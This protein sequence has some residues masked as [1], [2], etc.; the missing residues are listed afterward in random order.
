[1]REFF[2]GNK[3]FLLICLISLIVASQITFERINIE[4]K[5]NK[6]DIVLDYKEISDMAEQSSHSVEWWLKKFKDM[7]INKVGLSEE[8]IYSLT[9]ES[10]IQVSAKMIYELKKEPLW[11]AKLPVDFLA[12]MKKLGV[13][14]FDMLVQM[15]DDSTHKFVSDA[16]NDRY[17][18]DKFILYK[19]SVG[20]Y[21]FLKGSAEEALYSQKEKLVDSKKKGF[22]EKSEI[23][24][25]KVGYI[26][27]GLLD[28]KKKILDDLGFEIIPRTS[29]YDNW[30]SSKYAKAVLKE[31][32]ALRIQPEYMIV[33]GEGI[34][35]YDD[36]IGLINEYIKNTDVNIGVIETTTQRS[37]IMQ[38][39]VNEVV[40]NSGYSAV[41]VFSVWD[42]IQNRYKYYGYSGSEEIENTFF[43]AITERNIRVIYFKPIRQTDD[44]SVYVTD[45]S[46]YEKLFK[47][48]KDRLEVHGITQGKATVMDDYSVS[49]IQKYLLFLASIALGIMI[50]KSLFNIRKR[51]LVILLGILVVLS[52]LGF[53]FAPSHVDFFSSFS[54]AVLMPCLAITLMLR[55]IKKIRKGASSFGK[56]MLRFEVILVIVVLMAVLGGILTAAPLSSINYLLEIDIFRGVKMAQ[57]L[58]LCYFMVAFVAVFGFGRESAIKEDSHL[59]VADLR[60]IFLM[61][62]KVW[63]VLVVMILGGIGVYYI[64]RTGHESSA[65]ISSL[66]MLFRNTLEDNLFARPRTKEFLFAFPALVLF[67]Y[68]VKK[69]WKLAAFILG[70]A[71]TIGVTSVVNTFMHLR[72]PMILGFAR[73]GYSLLFGVVLS[74]VLLI[75][76]R[77]IEL[78][79]LKIKEEIHV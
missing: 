18:S 41:R 48:L 17:D 52:G 13:N 11:E 68:S 33:G 74:A 20:G 34:P 22:R 12:D 9:E 1:M 53:M 6:Y 37:N 30:N 21:L 38:K 66:E 72:T 5:N 27:L 2:K 4:D 49:L 78:L 3:I 43:R 63:M 69:G 26:N 45:V 56:D 47:N 50:L 25:S 54:P 79:I 59:R 7:G 40:M 16:M 28:S 60:N 75:G 14:E 65:Q 24:G 29:S 36:G 46:E 8:S 71:G 70:L 62:I 64:M 76:I 44:Y 19:N 58:P 67:M 39:G 77:L 42:Y 32:D 15:A 35:G 10:N 23:V 61:E 57:L 73:T 31:Y 51:N 55:E